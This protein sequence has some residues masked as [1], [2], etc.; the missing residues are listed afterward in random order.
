MK[1]PV[2]YFPNI[3]TEAVVQRR[4]SPYLKMADKHGNMEWSPYSTD[5]EAIKSESS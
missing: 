1:S 2:N 4:T 5:F 3:N